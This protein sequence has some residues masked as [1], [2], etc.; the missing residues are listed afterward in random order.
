MRFVA[1]IFF[2]LALCVAPFA[3][4]VEVNAV[5]C[6]LQKVAD[7]SVPLKE[8]YAEL[9]KKLGPKKASLEKERKELEAKASIL[10]DPKTSKADRD[11]FVARQ[12]AYIEKTNVLVKQLSDAELTVRT[13]MDTI[14]L[15]AAREYANR[16]KLTLVLDTQSVLFQDSSLKFPDVTS[17]MVLEVNRLWAEAKKR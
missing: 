15:Q 5:V 3:H 2:A 14:I 10:T 4:A 12:S 9:E 16:N 11:A 17:A 1:G 7:S 6:D 13:Q 8:A